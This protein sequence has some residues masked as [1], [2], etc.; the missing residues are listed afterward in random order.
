D[1]VVREGRAGEVVDLGVERLAGEPGEGVDVEILL[2]VSDDEEDG[3]S[4]EPADAKGRPHRELRV[5]ERVI[6]RRRPGG[7][8]PDPRLRGGER[9]EDGPVA[10]RAG[11]EVDGP[12]LE[13]VDGPA[14]PVR[15]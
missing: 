2:D 9:R 15:E 10:R 7:E 6:A 3:R 14:G 1:A 5:G 13:P 11:R 12:R 8:L 4:G